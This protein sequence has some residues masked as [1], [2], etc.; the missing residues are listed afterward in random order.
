M[1]GFVI[2]L[3]LGTSGVRAVAVDGAG[4]I[5]GS[6]AAQLPATRVQGSRREQSPEDWWNGCRT[7]LDELSKV[8]DLAGTRAIAVDATSGTILP[9][10]NHNRPLALARMYDD[11]DTGEL[12]AKIKS[13]LL[14][15]S[16]SPRDS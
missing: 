4:T 10:D 1:H 13:C 11:A 5:I 2:G 3:D 7:A 12:A 15:T 9:V 16:P 6:G 8:L 14:Y